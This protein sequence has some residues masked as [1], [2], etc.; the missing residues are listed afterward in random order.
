MKR[1]LIIALAILCAV[2]LYALTR[3][4]E[5]L[6]V[7]TCPAG[8]V[9][10]GSLCYTPCAK[11]YTG[12]ASNC[13]A[14]NP[15]TINLLGRACQVG[16]TKIGTMCY[17][18]CP[19]V[20]PGTT[21]PPAT[22]KGCTYSRGAGTTPTPPVSATPTPAVVAKPAVAVVTTPSTPGLAAAGT[23]SSLAQTA[24]SCTL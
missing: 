12:N 5:G 15:G 13:F 21:L 16:S 2:V 8:K 19:A 7:G 1:E 4:R 18:K 22:A 24:Q 23:S 20:P 14:S 3:N 10:E 17:P 9:L 6:A 11:G